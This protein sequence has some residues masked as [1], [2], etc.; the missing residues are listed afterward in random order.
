MPETPK[1]PS[2]K[3]EREKIYKKF[4]EKLEGVEKEN[5]NDL[6]DE[7]IKV[8][9]ENNPDFEIGGA[10]IKDETSDGRLIFRLSVPEMG[11]EGRVKR[12][13]SEIMWHIHDFNKEEIEKRLKENTHFDMPSHADLIGFSCT[14]KRR[15]EFIVGPFYVVKLE[16]P[17]EEESVYLR[18]ILQGFNLMKQNAEVIYNQFRNLFI[19]RGLHA[20]IDLMDYYFINGW[21]RN[22]G[23]KY[24]KNSWLD[25]VRKCG[26][27]VTITEVPDEYIPKELKEARLKEQIGLT[28]GEYEP[29]QD[30]EFD[31][32]A[33]SVVNEVEEFVKRIKREKI[34]EEEKRE[35]ELEQLN[36]N[37]G[38]LISGLR[39]YES[40]PDYASVLKA[41]EKLQSMG[42]TNF[43]DFVRDLREGKF[44]SN[45]EFLEELLKSGRGGKITLP[46]IVLN[47]IRKRIKELKE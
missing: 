20:V 26:V 14:P 38:N 34:Q 1:Q 46:P 7:I 22:F 10:I 21:E 37:I 4:I 43:K 31:E 8:R 42:Y 40:D 27:K 47:E 28:P 12:E 15:V 18:S 36:V 6:I 11:E 3:K 33:R 13:P 19:H 23:T 25:F 5:C 24:D 44:D 30:K 41:Y 2:P 39:K 35:E 32:W 45:Q 16:K 17:K 29:V 9:Y